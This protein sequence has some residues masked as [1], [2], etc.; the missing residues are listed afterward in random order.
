MPTADCLLQPMPRIVQ[1]TNL[2]IA[3]AAQQLR[4]GAAVA[5]PTE[6]VY[7][8]GADTFSEAA[9]GLV[10]QMKGRPFNNPLIAHVLDWEQAAPLVHADLRSQIANFKSSTADLTARFWPGPLTLVLPKSDDVPTCATAGLSTI[11]IRAPAHPVARRLLQTFGSPISAPSANRSG[12]VSP[13]AAAHVAQDFADTDLL[14]LDGGPCEVGIESTVVDLS[15][16]G[17]PSILRPGSITAG[18]LRE[19]MPDLRTPRLTE[20]A[21]SPGTAAQHYAPRTPAEIVPS[22]QLVRRLQG[23]T[24]PMAVLA[25]EPAIVAAPHRPI[26][27]PAN[28]AGYA[29]SLYRALR[30]ADALKCD[31]ILIEEPPFDDEQWRAIHDRIRRAAA[32]TS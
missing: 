23:A 15:G 29:Q 7:G 21:S 4:A 31:R 13:T 16:S 3:E 9:I 30:E 24:G 18:Q 28:A 5:F 17:P 22:S 14:I 20:Q 25:F 26:V 32:A 6:T 1:P 27:M 11:A 2:M 10:Y 19:F 8:L 12:H